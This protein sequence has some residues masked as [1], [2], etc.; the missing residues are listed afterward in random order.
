MSE[1]KTVKLDEDSE[2]SKSVKI[3][4]GA[5]LKTGTIISIEDLS[6]YPGQEKINTFKSGNPTELYLILTI[7]DTRRKDKLFFLRGFF[8]R[9]KNTEQIT[10]W[11]EWKNPI[12]RLFNKVLGEF[13]IYQD[14]WSVPPVLLIKLIG[15]SFQFVSFT[16]GGEP[17]TNDK[18]QERANYSDWD[19]VFAIGESIEVIKEEFAADSEYLMGNK[20]DKYRYDPGAFEKY[21]SRDGNT[22]FNYGENNKGIKTSPEDD[23]PDKD[24]I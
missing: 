7:D 3:S 16:T 1:R 22:D 15:K 6:N 13:E 18:G 5:Y 9:D 23:I 14:N 11:N 19:K 4:T 12:I 21:S 10:G 17:W 24:V 8:K 2:D 20:T